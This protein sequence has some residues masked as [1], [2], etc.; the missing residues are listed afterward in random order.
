MERRHL[1]EFRVPFDEFIG[2]EHVGSG[3]GWFKGRLSIRPEFI[4]GFGNLHGGMA[5]ALLDTSMGLAATAACSPWESCATMHIDIQIREPARFGV[6][7][8]NAKVVRRG[9][10]SGFLEGEVHYQ[11]TLLAKAQGTWTFWE[12]P[13]RKVS[14]DVAAAMKANP[15]ASA[16]VEAYLIERGRAEFAELRF[17]ELKE[18][19]ARLT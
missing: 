13:E 14:Y 2:L 1:R 12:D 17:P 5:I 16:V 8:V 4:N 9:K 15:T 18:L 10:T 11:G 6:L 7:E 3:D 19:L